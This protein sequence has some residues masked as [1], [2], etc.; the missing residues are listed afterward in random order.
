MRYL[1]LIFLIHLG[2]KVKSQDLTKGILV[3]NPEGS[4]VPCCVFIPEAG[5]T[6]YNMPNGDTIAQLELG[7]QDSNGEVYRAFVNRSGSQESFKYPNL[8]MVGYEVMAVVYTD[9][10][11]GYVK[12]GTDYWIDINELNSK[13]L[14]LESWMDYLL[15]KEDVL[16]WYAIDPGLN[17][18]TEPN[19]NA[20]L[21]VT[22]KG[23]LWEITPTNESK[24]LWCKV[25]VKEYREHP[26]SGGED[27]VIRTLTGWVKLLSD[28]QTPN[29]WNY[30]KG[31]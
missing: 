5:L 17:L 3:R 26:C 8:F 6:L 11:D 14:I 25:T 7:E 19:P 10:R 12:I 9:R 30:G 15:N 18:R 1:L 16:G 4:N 23:N 21:L 31:C 20:E 13:G 27:L 28:E 2:L 24:G 22:L 29:V